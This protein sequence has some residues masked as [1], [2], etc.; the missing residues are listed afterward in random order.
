M[1]INHVVVAGNLTRDPELKATSSGAAVLE[2]GMA[3]ND[4][5]KGADGEWSDRANFFDVVVWG[6]RGEALESIL[7]KGMKVTVAGRL[8]WSSWETADGQKR[9]RVQIV[10]E[11][12]EL[13]AKGQTSSRPAHVTGARAPAPADFGDDDDIPF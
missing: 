3:V 9:S 6:R 8:R 4:R 7:A 2:F 11:D 10:G 1:S 13:P 5:V 12:V